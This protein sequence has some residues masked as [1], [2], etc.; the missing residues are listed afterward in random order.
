MPLVAFCLL[1]GLFPGGS[2]SLIPRVLTALI[3]DP[4]TELTFYEFLEFERG[5]GALLAGPCSGA[6]L[7]KT[8][9]LTRVRTMLQ[10]MRASFCLT[11]QPF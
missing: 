5:L 7:G 10:S 6:L 8:F 3:D 9:T 2:E 4:A 11:V 1:Y